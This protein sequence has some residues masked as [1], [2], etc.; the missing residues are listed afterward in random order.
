MTNLGDE[1]TVSRTLPSRQSFICKIYRP[2]KYS[3]SLFFFFLLRGIDAAEENKEKKILSAVARTQTAVTV[4]QV[5]CPSYASNW[6]RLSSAESG[7][8]T[9][10]TKSPHHSFHLPVTFLASSIYKSLQLIRFLSWVAL[11]ELLGLV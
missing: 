4:I 10:Y 5:Q 1:N 9:L 11:T 6:Y 7:V 3:N 2:R 8:Y